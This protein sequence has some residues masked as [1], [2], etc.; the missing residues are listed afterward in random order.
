MN[1]PVESIRD[2]SFFN[3]PI[4]LLCQLHCVCVQAVSSKSDYTPLVFSMSWEIAV[5]QQQ[6]KVCAKS[7]H[8]L[9]LTALLLL[10]SHTLLILCSAG[11]HLR[12]LGSGVHRVHG[13]QGEQAIIR[14]SVS[15]SDSRQYSIGMDRG[16]SSLQSKQNIQAWSASEQHLMQW[17]VVTRHNWNLLIQA[18]R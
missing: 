14:L 8:G 12:S 3:C 7:L 5:K 15:L 18:G 10:C 4:S 9:D 16:T 17:Q 1:P 2:L 11:N 6:K 13:Y